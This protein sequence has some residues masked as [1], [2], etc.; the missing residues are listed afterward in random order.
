MFVPIPEGSGK[1][2]VSH[3]PVLPLPQHSSSQLAVI[4]LICGIC[5][6]SLNGL[7]DATDSI[8]VVTKITCQH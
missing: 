5:T 2:I 7:S 3:S 1:G 4:A 6:P 8:W